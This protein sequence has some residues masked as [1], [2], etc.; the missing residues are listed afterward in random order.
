[1]RRTAWASARTRRTCRPQGCHR[2]CPGRRG[3]ETSRRTARLPARSQKRRPTSSTHCRP[4]HDLSLRE[5]SLLDVL[6]RQHDRNAGHLRMK[7]ATDATLLSQSATTRLIARLEDQGSWRAICTPP[8]AAA[9]K[10]TSPKRG[11][12]L[13]KRH[14]PPTT[15]HC[16]RRSTKQPRIPNGPRCSGPWSHGTRPHKLQPWEI[17]KYAQPSP[18]T[19]PP[20]SRCSPTTPWAPGGSHRTT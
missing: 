20:S 14:I 19:S 17:L 18:T 2:P 10:R 16:A 13:P 3:R 12:N 4:Q 7:Q 5:H 11:S 15:P 8:T 9:S 1:M 6:S